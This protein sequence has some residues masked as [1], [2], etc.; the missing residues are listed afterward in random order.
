MRGKGV[1]KPS[2]KRGW[3][4]KETKILTGRKMMKKKKKKKK[5]K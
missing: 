5:R 2:S 1:K 4:L 3:K